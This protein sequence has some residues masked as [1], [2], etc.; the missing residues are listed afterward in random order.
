VSVWPRSIVLFFLSVF[1]GLLSTIANAGTLYL[2]IRTQ[3]VAS[4]AP[5]SW[6][7]AMCGWAALIRSPIS[8]ARETST[9]LADKQ[10]D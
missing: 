10:S 1:V 7:Q 6:P 8:R 4:R 5:G 9:I 3:E 2:S